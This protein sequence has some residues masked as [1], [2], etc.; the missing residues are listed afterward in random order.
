V[1]IRPALGAFTDAL[2]IVDDSG[3]WLTVGQQLPEALGVRVTDSS[4][5]HVA[6]IT[7]S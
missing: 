1:A 7:G 4:A 3:Q 2:V 5:I 6:G